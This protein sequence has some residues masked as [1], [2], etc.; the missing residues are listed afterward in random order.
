MLPRNLPTLIRA[1]IALMS[2]TL[3]VDHRVMDG[4]Q[5]A[6]FLSDL[7][8]RLEKPYFLLQAD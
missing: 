1:F 5:G 3:T 4:I 2:L 6:Q 7:K 8:A